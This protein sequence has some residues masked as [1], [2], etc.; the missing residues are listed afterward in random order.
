LSLGDGPGFSADH[1]QIVGV[2]DIV[3]VTEGPQRAD[4]L[5]WWKVTTRVGVAGWGINDHLL[6]FSGEC[7]G[8]AGSSA[9]PIAASPTLLSAAGTSPGQ[10]QLPATGAGSDGLI[11][12]G[13]LVF[14]LLVVGLARR[15]SQGT[16]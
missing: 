8:G 2:D 16:I 11:F 7:F 14:V 4:G 15:R 1:V 12:A 3:F 13:V 6:P 9:P 5:W 10:S